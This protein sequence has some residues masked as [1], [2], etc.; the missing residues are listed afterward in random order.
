[1]TFKS[2]LA[3]RCCDFEVFITDG[4]NHGPSRSIVIGLRKHR[5]VKITGSFSVKLKDE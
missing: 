5:N 2:N 4:G 3:F 1:M